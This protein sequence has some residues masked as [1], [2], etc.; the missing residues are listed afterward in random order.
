MYAFGVNADEIFDAL[1][2]ANLSLPV[3]RFQDQ[4][5]VT[6]NSRL[7]TLKDYENLIIKQKNDFKSKQHIVLLKQVA[8]IKLQADDKKFRIRVNG[9]PG[10]CIALQKSNDDNPLEVSNLVHQQFEDFYT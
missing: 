9:K 1:Q 10:I 8:D 3:G 5:S 4:I 2:R 6:L 7:E